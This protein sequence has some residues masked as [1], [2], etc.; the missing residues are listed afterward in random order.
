VRPQAQLIPRP[1]D[2][3]GGGM[4][5]EGRGAPETGRGARFCLQDCT[6]L[7]QFLSPRTR[8]GKS[9]HANPVHLAP[10]VTEAKPLP[11]P[12]NCARGG[13]PRPPFP[14]QSPHAP[15]GI[16]QGRGLGA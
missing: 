14:N 2:P 1:P 4:R 12:Q 3:R 6:I 11:R 10:R 8:F 5:A 9:S 7:V 15:V 16:G 13:A